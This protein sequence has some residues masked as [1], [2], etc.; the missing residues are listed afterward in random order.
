MALRLTCKERHQA[1]SYRAMMRRARQR[2]PQTGSRTEPQPMR[3]ACTQ[4]HKAAIA[5][6][7]CLATAIRYGLEKGGVQVAHLRFSSAAHGKVNPGL[8][9]KPHDKWTLP[10]CPEEH[11]QQHAGSEQAYWAELGVDPHQI[12]QDLWNA[13]PNLQEMQRVLRKAM[14]ARSV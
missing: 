8:Q 6:L 7:F 13:S 10:L 5:Q 3:R 9:R 4:A 1:K 14:V 2:S 11:R 12:A